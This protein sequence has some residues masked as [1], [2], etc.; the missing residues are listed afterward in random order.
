MEP[1]PH[2]LFMATSTTPAEQAT[3]FEHILGFSVLRGIANKLLQQRSPGWIMHVNQTVGTNANDE[4]WWLALKQ[5]I[6]NDPKVGSEVMLHVLDNAERMVAKHI[7]EECGT[8]SACTHLI[9]CHVAA[10]T[11]ALLRNPPTAAAIARRT[12]LPQSNDQSTVR[13]AVPSGVA[14][15]TFAPSQP[16]PSIAAPISSQMPVPPPLARPATPAASELAPF[17]PAA[18]AAPAP[19]MSPPPVATPTAAVRLLPGMGAA[20]ATAGV[21][22][23]IDSSGNANMQ[24]ALVRER[25]ATLRP[26]NRLFYGPNGV[27]LNILASSSADAATL[28]PLLAIAPGGSITSSSWGGGPPPYSAAAQFGQVLGELRMHE[29]AILSRD[30]TARAA[31]SSA[32]AGE[33]AMRLARLELALQRSAAELARRTA[34]FSEVAGAAAT[35]LQQRALASQQQQ[36]RSEAE[37]AADAAVR[38]LAQARITEAATA[39]GIAKAD[40]DA[41]VFTFGALL[42]SSKAAFDTYPRDWSDTGVLGPS[43]AGL[44]HCMRMGAQRGG[45]RLFPEDTL[46][47]IDSATGVATVAAMANSG[48]ASAVP[49]VATTLSVP[50]AS[51]SSSVGPT[52]ADSPAA[53]AAAAAAAPSASPSAAA[54]AGATPALALS[55]AAAAAAFLTNPYAW[56]H[57]LGA[58]LPDPKQVAISAAEWSAIAGTISAATPSPSSSSST[59]SSASSSSS[60][61]APPLPPHPKMLPRLMYVPSPS[62]PITRE[63]PPLD[64]APAASPQRTAVVPMGR[65]SSLSFVRDMLQ[66]QT[67]HVLSGVLAVARARQYRVLAGLAA[68]QRRVAVAAAGDA[69]EGGGIV[70]AEP[71]FSQGGSQQQQQRRGEGGAEPYGLLVESVPAP[72]QLL[73]MQPRS[74]LV[75]SKPPSA[76]LASHD[77]DTDTVM[78]GTASSTSTSFVVPLP[79]PPSEVL[80]NG[81]AIVAAMWLHARNA[82]ARFFARTSTDLLRVGVSYASQVALSRAAG[83]PPPPCPPMSI[84][85]AAAPKTDDHAAAA[86]MDSEGAAA[87]AAQPQQAVAVASCNPSSFGTSSV[88]GKGGGG[89]SA[90]PSLG[91]V[92]TR[93]LC[94]CIQRTCRDF[95]AEPL[96]RLLK[97]CLGGAIP[98]TAR[99]EDYVPVASG[100][101]SAAAGKS[102]LFDALSSPALRIPAD[103]VRVLGSSI[104]L[105]PDGGVQIPSVTEFHESVHRAA[106]APLR[107]SLAD[108]EE[109][110]RGQLEGR[111]PEIPPASTSSTAAAAGPS[112]SGGV[113]G[114]LGDP[115]SDGAVSLV[116]RKDAI[117]AQVRSAA[118]SA[119]ESDLLEWLPLPSTLVTPLQ[120]QFDPQEQRL[121]LAGGGEDELDLTL[122]SAPPAPPTASAPSAERSIASSSVGSGAGLASGAG[123]S[124]CSSMNMGGADAFALGEDKS[125]GGGAHTD[126]PHDKSTHDEPTTSGAGGD[127]SL[128][129]GT[130]KRG[131]HEDNDFVSTLHTAADDL[132]TSFTP[133]GGITHHDDEGADAAATPVGRSSRASVAKRSK[134]AE[135]DGA[136][137][138]P[139][140]T[141]APTRG[142]R[143]KGARGGKHASAAAAPLPPAAA[144]AA[145]PSTPDAAP[146]AA[147]AAATPAESAPAESAAAA[148]ASV[149]PDASATV[150]GSALTPSTTSAAAAPIMQDVHTLV[151]PPAPAGTDVEIEDGSSST[152]SLTALRSRLSGLRQGAPLLGSHP[153]TRAWLRWGL[154]RAAQRA[155][156]AVERQRVEL[157]AAIPQPPPAAAAGSTGSYV[158]AAKPRT[159]AY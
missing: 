1:S 64:A 38:Q 52:P 156:V 65:S 75:D 36:Q 153:R 86:M 43:G 19:A 16:Q 88:S 126:K 48:S 8:P 29:R 150:S 2:R 3:E 14:A 7:I 103:L 151:P 95:Y 152:V 129:R 149:T 4:S 80:E 33:L 47:A 57:G 17:P 133:S 31:S 125:V 82:W 102:A 121:Q 26:S 113:G 134:A 11:A 132:H 137:V 155:M 12:L 41:L 67:L 154:G 140:P 98:H 147:T 56:L 108:V 105:F 55:T 84:N 104:V 136:V 131:R 37:S 42:S 157:M 59:S 138:V 10:L 135:D 142:G 111:G 76:A 89:S 83:T 116:Y 91:D 139:A 51:P 61:A 99:V 53:A 112:H 54:A 49:V 85:W 143:G 60:A 115:D 74:L 96:E 13:V 79:V 40:A 78:A 90:P 22:T 144:P 114:A 68:L 50:A 73:A 70:S 71:R 30:D 69:L 119:G 27:S 127:A 118:A 32:S 15:A 101:T 46:G 23:A 158:A 81:D 18:A 45:V 123:T 130:R 109:Y 39:A 146:G 124:L 28:F 92:Y 106:T 72:S 62:A 120:Q 94:V 21:T 34:A 24:M 63:P 141:A 5:L 20:L 9:G 110:L 148:A 44:A 87:V 93:F 145:A 77:E 117:L 58:W 159:K 128:R 6:L 107:V 122:A 25:L 100:K 66:V 97:D 35:A